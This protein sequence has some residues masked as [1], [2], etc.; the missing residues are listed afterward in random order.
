MYPST[1]AITVVSDP[2]KDD[3]VPPMAP[4]GSMARALKFENT[5][6]SRNMIPASK[7][8]KTQNGKRPNSASVRRAAESAMKRATALR[9]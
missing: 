3:A 1:A 7:S 5:M 2:T 6:P 4:W 9:P 8:M